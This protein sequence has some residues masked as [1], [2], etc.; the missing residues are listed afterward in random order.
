MN[1]FKFDKLFCFLIIT[2]LVLAPSLYV[3]M[4]SD[5]YSYFLMGLSPKAHYVHYMG[6]SGRLVTDY[7]SPLILS[8]PHTIYEIINSMVFSLLII[9]IASIP[10]KTEDSPR[11]SFALRAAF[12]FM[13][14][15]VANPNLGQ[16]SFWIVG[17]ANYLWTNMF[18]AI[19]FTYL[20]RILNK[21]HSNSAL[22][23]SLAFL[24]GCSNENTSIMVIL[25]TVFITFYEHASTKIK[26]LSV[27]GNVV[28]AAILILAPGNQVRAS[29]FENWYATSFEY[30]VFAHFFYRFPQ[31]VSE[32]WQVYLVLIIAIVVS[33]LSN[34][35]R[36]S[37]IIYMLVF[38][39]A[40]IL[41]NAALIGSPVVPPR[42][43]NGGLCLLLISTSFILVDAIRA[44][45]KFE[46]G[47]VGLSLM[48]CAFYFL[49]SYVLFNLAM[50]ATYEQSK[51]RD[52]IVLSEKSKGIKDIYIPEFY[53]PQLIKYYDRFDLS[54]SK[55]M[56]KYFG[57]NSINLFKIGFDYSRINDAI[58]TS[59]NKEF[60][61]GIY[62][63]NIYFYTETFGMK[64]R[65]LLEFNGPINQKK[66]DGDKIF[67]HVYL[68]GK[69]GFTNLDTDI[70]PV[71][72]GGRYYI[73]RDVKFKSIDD[74]EKIRIGVFNMHTKINKVDYTLSP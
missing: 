73:W 14:Y 69:G 72:I 63:K 44:Y 8:L 19:Y 20:F 7:I 21:S 17:S 43:M 12:V 54:H 22:L 2:L 28:G 65:V 15:W 29:I 51:I 41:S 49:P 62:L 52:S 11:F 70:S 35:L 16:T 45:G 1:I 6:W 9:F 53:F 4:H 3:P 5:D 10:I 57:V 61:N 42:S 50:R 37:S 13:L 56:A 58:K 55:F 23:V 59:A 39:V 33:A 40:S 38:F 32:Y 66:S 60:Y 30:R 36:R 26:T 24:A 71:N 46:R 34:T 68:K 25:C 27:L 31:A 48:F 67:M 47:M 64:K 74:V 18:I